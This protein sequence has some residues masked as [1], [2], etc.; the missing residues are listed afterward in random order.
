[1][2]SKFEV[3][4][5]LSGGDSVAF[6]LNSLLL[7][8][9]LSKLFNNKSSNSDEPILIPEK[10]IKNK[11]IKNLLSI[12]ISIVRKEFNNVSVWFKQYLFVFTYCL[13]C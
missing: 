8:D 6:H 2:N 9:D 10:E 3:K 4:K 13:G 7:N 5:V 12:L 1:M 11:A